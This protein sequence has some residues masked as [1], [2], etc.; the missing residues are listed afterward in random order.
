[1]SVIARMRMT[2]KQ[3]GGYFALY[4]GILPGTIRSFMSNGTSMIVM[5]FAHRKVSEWGLRGKSLE[6][7]TI[8]VEIKA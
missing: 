4:R 3:R 7:E 8:E 1:M 5:A 6:V 2:I